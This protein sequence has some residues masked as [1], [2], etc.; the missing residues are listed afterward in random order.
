V[1]FG[2]PWCKLI[3]MY[4]GEFRDVLITYKTDHDSYIH[5]PGRDWADAPNP[6]HILI[7]LSQCAGLTANHDMQPGSLFV[8]TAFIPF[9][10]ERGIIHGTKT[11]L[12]PNRLATDWKY[13]VTS[14]R[15]QHEV[16]VNHINASYRSANR[17]KLHGCDR[18]RSLALDDVNTS[19]PVLQVDKIWLPRDRP[20]TLV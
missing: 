15:N 16:I 7:S 11:Y 5:T 4:V 18:A 12:V 19:S 3:E 1:K 13:I 8:P 17:D 9:D 2:T 6:P 14:H 10:I 20:L